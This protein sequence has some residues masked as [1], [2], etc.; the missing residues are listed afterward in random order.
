MIIKREEEKK[1][2]LQLLRS[3]VQIPLAALILRALAKSQKLNKNLPLMGLESTISRTD[4]HE[5]FIRNPI[6]N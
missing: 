5:C 2:L 4:N 1:K 6:I 3:W